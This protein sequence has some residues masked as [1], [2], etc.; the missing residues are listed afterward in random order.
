MSRPR[1]PQRQQSA[2]LLAAEIHEYISRQG[3]VADTVEGVA[4]WWLP[5]QRFAD[6]LEV[7]RVA[8]EKLVSEGILAKRVSGERE[9]YVTVEKRDR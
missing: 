1:R 2:D 9:I 8:L 3:P 7:V 6:S 4:Y 5:Q